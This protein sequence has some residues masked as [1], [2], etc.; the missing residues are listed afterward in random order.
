MNGRQK[1]LNECTNMGKVKR[2]KLMETVHPVRG[3]RKFQIDWFL[4]HLGIL[5]FRREWTNSLLP[6]TTILRWKKMESVVSRTGPGLNAS[7]YD[8][9]TVPQ[10][11]RLR[12]VHRRTRS[13]NDHQNWGFLQRQCEGI[14]KPTV[15]SKYSEQYLWMATVGTTCRIYRTRVLDCLNF[16]NQNSETRW[17]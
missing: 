5:M 17:C 15:S 3:L 13:G 9:K 11:R 8:M 6:K 10:M 7:R 2:L 1:K 16:F 14:L 4:L 12:R